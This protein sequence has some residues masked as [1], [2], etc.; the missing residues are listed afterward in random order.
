MIQTGAVDF[1]VHT[2]GWTLGAGAGD[3][4]FVS[5]D[6]PFDP[7][8]GTPPHVAVA[9]SGVDAAQSANLRLFV[10]T[11]DVEAGEFN[12]VVSTWDDTLVF[13]VRITWIAYDR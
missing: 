5:P 13:G 4:S 7:P 1:N 8:F 10:E 6:I 2:S 12:I 3:R 11:S 9:I